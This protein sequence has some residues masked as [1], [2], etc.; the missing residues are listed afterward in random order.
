MFQ[1][2]SFFIVFS[3]SLWGFFYSILKIIII[4]TKTC[5]E[6]KGRCTVYAKQSHFFEM[7]HLNKALWM[8]LTVVDWVWRSSLCFGVK[9]LMC[10]IMRNDD[11][12][13]K[14]RIFGLTKCNQNMSFSMLCNGRT[15][16][17]RPTCKG[18][19]V[20]ISCSPAVQ[21]ICIHPAGAS[22]DLCF[23]GNTSAIAPKCQGAC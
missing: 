20:H 14:V 9:L 5:Y 10:L 15:H 18:D 16:E 4:Y 8:R 21:K 19:C 3:A 1:L 7:R 17:S 12:T 22:M 2:V 6:F 13:Y 11:I 23:L